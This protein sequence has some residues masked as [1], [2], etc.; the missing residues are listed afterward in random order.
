M[1]WWVLKGGRMHTGRSRNDEVATC[2]RIALRD[3][4]LDLMAEEL[5][6]IKTL[7]RLAAN[8]RESVIPGF[9]HPSMLSPPPWPIIY[10]PMPMLPLGIWV[11]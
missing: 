4:L 1:L 2:I 5:S 10:W 6:F 3:D 11:G 8:H 7:V 9:S